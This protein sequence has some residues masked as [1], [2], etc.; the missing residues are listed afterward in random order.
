MANED[1]V[2]RPNDITNPGDSLSPDA[3]RPASADDVMAAL[4]NISTGKVASPTPRRRGR[5]PGSRNRSAA[6][7]LADTNPDAAKELEAQ[8]KREAKK[9]RAEELEKQIYTELN[10]QLMS[11]VITMFSVP[12][13]FLYNPGKEP[14]VAAKDDR[15]TELGQMFAIPPGLAK[16]V[17][18]LASELEQTEAGSKISGVTQNSNVGLIVAGGMTIFGTV[19]YARRISSTLEKIRPFLEARKQHIEQQ[20]NGQQPKQTD[21][22]VS[23]SGSVS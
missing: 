16:S 9:R 20:T 14:T 17:G 10:D 7:K 21:S 18:R 23:N 12:A 11:M 5:P 3:L 6:E 22:E 4:G 13:E 2:V 8:A 19:Q 1:S 15:F